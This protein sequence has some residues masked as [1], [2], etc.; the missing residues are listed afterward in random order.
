ML[1]CT[2]FNNTWFGTCVK[3]Q[4]HRGDC[5]TGEGSLHTIKAYSQDATEEGQELIFEKFT[6]S[7][8]IEASREEI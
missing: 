5:L 1:Y 7:P 2:K 8:L 6:A 3:E 4:E